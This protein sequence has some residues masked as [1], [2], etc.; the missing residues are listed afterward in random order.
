MIIFCKTTEKDFLRLMVT[1]DSIQK[2]NKDNLKFYIAV[3][4]KDIRELDV[5]DIEA[6]IEI[7]SE[8]DI[9]NLSQ[10]KMGDW[11]KQQVIKFEFCKN[12]DSDNCLILDSDSYFI[13]DFYKKDFFDNGGNL[14]TVIHRVDK[15]IDDY[16]YVGE[17]PEK[18]IEFYKSLRERI[19]NNFRNH[20]NL[21]D[22]GPPPVLWSKEVVLDFE[23]N[24][25]KEV[26]KTF[27]DIIREVPLEY[28]WY[29]EWLLANDVIEIVPTQP[30]FKNISSKEEYD[31]MKELK[32]STSDL[33]ENYFGINMQS[34][35]KPPLKY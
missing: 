26:G 1:I 6:D 3:D 23:K 4:E 16:K 17:I 27:V 35:W 24:Y 11:K 33:K 12:M 32:I 22:F 30:L 34:N 29:G 20:G 9:V 25:L 18:N 15:L 28:N 31:K 10:V 21:Y 14:Y 13:K 5:S 8:R 7:V 2:Y 19:K